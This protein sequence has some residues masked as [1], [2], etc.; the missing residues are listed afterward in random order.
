MANIYA[1]STVTLAA[2][3]SSGPH[4][5]LF[6]VAAP[7]LVG[8][9]ISNFPHIRARHS[10]ILGTQGLPLLERGWVFQERLLS[11][12]VLYFANNE[13]IWECMELLDCECQGTEVRYH[14]NENLWPGS[15]NLCHPAKWSSAKDDHVKLTDMWLKLTKDYAQLALSKP[16]DIFPAISGIAKSFG[17]ATGWNYYAGM[18]K[19]TMIYCLAWYSFGQNLPTRCVPWRAP[20][21]S[22]ASVQF[23][24]KPSFGMDYPEW[25]DLDVSA[26]V[27]EVV[28]CPKGD[29]P[30]GQLE[31]GYVIL[32]GTVVEAT[33]FNTQNG[34]RIRTLPPEGANAAVYSFDV[35]CNL[36]Q[37]GHEVHDGA[38]LFFLKLFN[39]K[40]DR[41]R[42]LDGN[43]DGIWLILRKANSTAWEW[44]GTKGDGEFERIGLHRGQYDEDE[45]NPRTLQEASS[46]QAIRLNA[47]VKII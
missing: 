9:P 29:D 21:F 35:D 8:W 15:K 1:N 3:A 42:K 18:W 11:P 38:S 5:G 23:N 36:K 32:S 40:S 45:T 30:T 22:W 44:N 12:R 33:I 7:E 13:L 4:E 14:Q 39:R 34:F 6:R 20:T 24:K 26:T 41:N 17:E 2:S 16:D 19:Q 28:C 47:K 43:S 27:M 31:S 25:K 10:L 46:E 37:A